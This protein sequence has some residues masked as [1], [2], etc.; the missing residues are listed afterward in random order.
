MP[1]LTLSRGKV[2]ARDGQLV[3][4]PAGASSSCD[5]APEASVAKIGYRHLKGLGGLRRARPDSMNLDWRNASFRCY[6]DYMQTDA[7]A[8]GLARLENSRTQRPTVIMC[9]EALPSRAI[10]R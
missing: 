7:F 4:G 5:S 10:G 3:S 1:R 9:A 6:V 8:A 2:I